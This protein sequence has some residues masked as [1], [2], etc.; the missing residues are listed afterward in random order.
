MKNVADIGAAERARKAARP[1]D[2]AGQRTREDFVPVR[3]YL[4]REFLRLEN[5]RLWPR[6]WQMAGRV[7]QIP[8]VGDY[9]TYDIGSQSI[10]VIR[11][12]ADIIKAFHNVCR[13]RGRRLLAECGSVTKIRCPYHSWTGKLDGSLSRILHREDW[14][15]CAEMSNEELHLFGVQVDTWS[16]FV[17]INMDPECESLQAFLDPLPKYHDWYEWQNMRYSWQRKFTAKANWK[18]ALE[19]FMESYHVSTGHSQVNAFIDA[20]TISDVFG[21]HGRV[22]FPKSR[23]FGHPSHTTDLPIPKDIRPQHV[24]AY[25][26]LV[27]QSGN[28]LQ[29]DANAVRRILT[30]LPAEATP[31]EVMAK[32]AEF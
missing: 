1:P 15:N 21:N 30:E 14:A 18:T 27:A 23:P 8:N 4:D 12:A 20:L 29:R 31:Q 25:D 22:S 5:E 26:A 32:A 16:G 10:I 13:H 7:E 17:F 28:V 2:L 24:V 6:I 11:V 3:N 19:A 9:L